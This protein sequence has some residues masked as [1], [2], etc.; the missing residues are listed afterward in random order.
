MKTH[1]GSTNTR[2]CNLDQDAVAD[3]L[4]RLGGG[5]LLGDAILLALED[6]EGKHV[7]CE[8]L[9]DLNAKTIS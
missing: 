9:N 6:G 2:G 4:V 1:T 5:A 7:E 8:G 3:E